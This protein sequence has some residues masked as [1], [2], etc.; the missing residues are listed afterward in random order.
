MN[1]SSTLTYNQL[2]LYGI[3]I[4]ARLSDGYI[5]ATQLCKAGH[6]NFDTWTR[7]KTSKEFIRLLTIDSS[8]QRELGNKPSIS[9]TIN[10]SPQNCGDAFIQ[11]ENGPSQTRAT[12]VHPDI[13]INIAQWISPEFS[14]RV[15]KWIRELIITG[16]VT[17]GSERNSD[18]IERLRKENIEQQQLL[19]E[20]T[21]IIDYQANRLLIIEDECNFRKKQYDTLEL[22]HNHLKKHRSLYHLQMGNAFYI[23][24]DRVNEN[25]YKIGHT[26]DVNNRFKGLSTGVAYL[27]VFMVVYTNDHK[28]LE[29][30]L[31]TTFKKFRQ[32]SNHEFINIPLQT[33]VK[34]VHATIEN[35]E[36]SLLSQEEIDRFNRNS[37]YSYE[38][39]LKMAAVD[40]SVDVVVVQEEPEPAKT[41]KRCGGFIHATEES[42]VLPIGSFHK[43][44]TNRDGYQRLCKECILGKKCG[45]DRSRHKV[46]DI[47]IVDDTKEKFCLRCESVKP[48]SQFYN[49]AGTRDGLNSNCKACKWEQKKKAKEVRKST[50]ITHKICAKCETNRPIK[51]FQVYVSNADGFKTWCAFCLQK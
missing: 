20:N 9:D 51:E 22:R 32:P 34:K 14:L 39:D 36:Y 8:R 47:P 46:V 45:V 38:E 31:L 50:T 25:R 28:L 10:A 15:S 19:S 6:R 23:I 35:W 41:H 27:K 33:L 12:W 21:T 16:D 5:N 24:S 48:F 7:K 11:Y 43:N 37:E 3:K 13:A 2:E 17:L 42:R 1:T 18:E 4:E 29:A 40:D 49:D 26:S 30:L 44:A